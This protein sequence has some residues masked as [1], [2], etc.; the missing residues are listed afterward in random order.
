MKLK[1][2]IINLCDSEIIIAGTVQTIVFESLSSREQ[3]RM[4]NYENEILNMLSFDAYNAI[5]EGLR[6]DHTAVV[7]IAQCRNLYDCGV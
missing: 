6:F 4:S 5:E 7:V 1:E 2:T 3:P